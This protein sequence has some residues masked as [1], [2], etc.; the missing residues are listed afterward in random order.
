MRTHLF[1]SDTQ[2]KPDIPLDHLTRLGKYIVDKKPDVI[3][4]IG[5]HWDM[6]SLSIYDK[7]KK[8]AEG[9]RYKQDVDAGN[10]GMKALLKPLKDLIMT[11]KPK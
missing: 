10:A 9:R 1:I 5:D 6:P 3:I 2:V 11:K 8:K 4:H 7:G